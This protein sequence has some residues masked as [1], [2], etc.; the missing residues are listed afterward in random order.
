MAASIWLVPPIMA[1]IACQWL[2]DG[3]AE[4]VARLK[5]H[6]SR[7]RAALI[8]RYLTSATLSYTPGSSH[9]WVQLPE[10]WQA[11]S[12]ARRAA[13]EGVMVIPSVNFSAGPHPEHQA[14]RLCLGPARSDEDLVHGASLLNDI[15]TMATQQNLL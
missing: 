13:S 12:F 2:I 5:R 6:E 10:P 15:V 8:R 4:R 7:R 3:T 14:I 1:E 11:E 9:L